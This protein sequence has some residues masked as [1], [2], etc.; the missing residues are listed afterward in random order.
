MRLTP[1]QCDEGR[2]LLDVYQGAG[3]PV[4]PKVILDLLC[5]D[6]HKPE[7]LCECAPPEPGKENQCH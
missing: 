2:R 5:A 3:P 6:C 7:G 4:P 1:K